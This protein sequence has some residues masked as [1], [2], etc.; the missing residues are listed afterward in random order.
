MQADEP[1]AERAGSVAV[2]CRVPDEA[3][4]FGGE[5]LSFNDLPADLDLAGRRP[6]DPSKEMAHAPAIDNRKQF[7]LRG[8]GDDID[9]EMG[10]IVL[11]E[12]RRPWNERRSTGPLEDSFGKLARQLMGGLLV[13]RSAQD[14]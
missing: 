1:Q 13:V 11:K 7:F 5:P 14:V 6:E 8:T 12:L 10:G 2:G 4:S 9:G 3:D